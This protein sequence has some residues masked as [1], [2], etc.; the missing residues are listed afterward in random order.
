MAQGKNFTKI[1]SFYLIING[2]WNWLLKIIVTVQCNMRINLVVIIHVRINVNQ[3]RIMIIRVQ[4]KWVKQE[5]REWFNRPG[6]WP[7]IINTSSCS[8]WL[9]GNNSVIHF[10]QNHV[11]ELLRIYKRSSVWRV[12]HFI[13]YIRWH[14]QHFTCF[15]CGKTRLLQIGQLSIVK[16]T[17]CNIQSEV[18]SIGSRHLVK[19][20]QYNKST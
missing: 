3:W 11:S 15:A 14:K 19:W 17:L 4:F 10:L 7:N 2:C 18:D 1:P 5:V 16:E 9:N 8:I 6:A 12:R 13:W 20:N